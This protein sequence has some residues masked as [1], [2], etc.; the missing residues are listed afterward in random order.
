MTAPPPYRL[1]RAPSAPDLTTDDNGVTFL[2]V[3]AAGP[4]VDVLFRLQVELDTGRRVAVVTTPTAAEWFDHYGVVPVI[5]E[6][7]GLPVRWRMPVPTVPTFEP[8]GSRLVA[9]PCSLNTL[10]K[11]AAGHSDNLALSL[12]CEA[13]GRGVPTAAEVSIS[14]PYANHPAATEALERL[15][16][17]GVALHRAHGAGD[18]PLLRPLPATV[19]AA[20]D[21]L[22]PAGGS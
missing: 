4:L 12:L 21:R 11:W 19:A 17:L 8:Q 6:K 18:H 20:L 13:T 1:R 5:E 22:T 2:I 7:T 10:T 14:G 16:S 15:G 9:S 3:S